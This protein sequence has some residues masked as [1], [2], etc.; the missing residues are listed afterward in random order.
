MVLRKSVSHLF[1]AV[2]LGFLCDVFT[3]SSMRFSGLFLQELKCSQRFGGC[4]IQNVNRANDNQ[5]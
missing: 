2:R 1:P 5:Y 3:N 4:K